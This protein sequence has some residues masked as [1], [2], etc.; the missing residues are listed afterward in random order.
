MKII[1]MHHAERDK[2]SDTEWESIERT[3][4][5]ITEIGKKSITI[6]FRICFKEVNMV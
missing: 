3:Y 4:D 2:S 6:L 5:D 1:Y